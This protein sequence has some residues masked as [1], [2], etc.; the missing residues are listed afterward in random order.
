MEDRMR[1]SSTCLRAALAIAGSAITL[2]YSPASADCPASETLC[3]TGDYRT[4]EPAAS[5]N[6]PTFKKMCD[7]AGLNQEQAE[8]D[9]PAGTFKVAVSEGG[10]MHLWLRDSFTITGPA[11]GTPITFHMHFQVN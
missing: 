4:G 9:L 10:S 8:F 2:A 11:P 7:F 5:T 1:C 6:D 3:G